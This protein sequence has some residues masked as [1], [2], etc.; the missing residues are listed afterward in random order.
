M[1]TLFEQTETC[2]ICGSEVDYMAVGSTNTFGSPD[3]DT[4]PP[5]MAR[6]TITFW[7]REC[8]SCGYCAPDLSR[9]Q[10][11]A[12]QT[13]RSSAYKSQLNHSAYPQLANRF[14]CW[15]MVQEAAGV[16]PS[17]GWAAVHA[18]WACDDANSPD[19]ADQCRLRAAQLFQEAKANNSRFAQGAGMEEA[20]LADLLRRSGRFEEAEMVCRQGLDA[21]AE[22]VVKQVL[23]FQARLAR[24]HDRKPYT[25]EEVE[26]AE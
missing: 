6:S 8:A 17:A 7:I 15:A 12:E 13:V 10:A 11:Q 22:D 18:A 9:E 25:I 21:G 14:L 4:R 26:G 3:L 1:T 5:E 20:I 23:T 16:Y 19:A 2:H 24:Q